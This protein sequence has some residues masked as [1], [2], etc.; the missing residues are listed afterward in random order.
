MKLWWLLLLFAIGSAHADPTYIYTG[1]W[2]K[3]FDDPGAGHEPFNDNHKL[4]AIQ[5]ERWQAGWFEN[6]YHRDVFFA[7]GTLSHQIKAFELS[8][9]GGLNYGYSHCLKGIKQTRMEPK[10]VCGYLN[11]AAFY[12]E[13]PVQ[14]GLILNPSFAALTVRWRL[15]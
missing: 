12:T 14:P 9:A 10:K 1:A 3:H 13:Y 7:G 8:L 15:Q 11:G 4:A 6:S 2:S 5:Y